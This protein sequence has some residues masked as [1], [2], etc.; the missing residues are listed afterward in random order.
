M[1]KENKFSNFKNFNSGITKFA[2]R[3]LAIVSS[4]I[5][6]LLSLGYLIKAWDLVYSP[7]GIV[8]GAS[9]TD[10]HVTLRFYQII[11]VASFIAAIITFI[12]HY[13]I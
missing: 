6:L 11:A 13:N 10:V 2:G 3:Q 7:R 8:F 1:N 9:Y 5:L 12:S 4:L